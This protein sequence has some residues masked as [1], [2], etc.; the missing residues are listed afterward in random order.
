MIKD[1][2]LVVFFIGIIFSIVFFSTT[3][4]FFNQ[5]VYGHIFSPDETASFI[6]FTDQLQV[7]SELVQA[8]LANNNLSLAQEHATKAAALLTPTIMI[9]IAEENQGIADDLTTA[10]NDLRKIS[11]PSSEKQRQIVNKLVSDINASLGEA[12]T[13][14]IKQAQRED[15]SNFLEKGIEFLRGIF[16]GGGDEEGD[17]KRDRNTTTQPLAF[18]DLV[19]SVLINYGNAYDVGFD[20]TNMSNMAMMESS[21]SSSSMAMSG[22]ADD[23]NNNNNSNMN[24]ASMNMSSSSSTMMNMDSKMDR[25][26]QLVNT[27]DYQ[28]AQALAAKALETFKAELKPMASNNSNNT[29]AFITNLENGLTQL[30][31]SIRSKASPMDIMMIVH[32]QVHPNLMQAFNLQLK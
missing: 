13:I 12:V 22:M 28:S 16:G 5:T 27:A 21:N 31:N 29:T 8:N 18:A 9:E 4:S 15:S 6:A 20:M 1:P 10:V 19:D 26:Y 24:M 30:N 14:R 23:N 32:S 3:N 11:S 7:E 2:P 17:D 25:N